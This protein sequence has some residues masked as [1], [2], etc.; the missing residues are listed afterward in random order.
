MSSRA[1]QVMYIISALVFA[2]M[3]ASGI[4]GLPGFGKYPGP[5]GDVI[6]GAVRA[7]RHIANAVTAIN[8]DYRGLDTLGEEFILF[9]A[10]TGVTLLLRDQPPEEEELTEEGG[11]PGRQR[12]GPSEALQWTGRAVMGA[13]LIFGLYII[14]HPQPSPGGGFQGGAIIGSASILVCLATNHRTYG[15]V[16]SQTVAEA[17][18]AGG[19]AGYILAGLAALFLGGNFLQNFLPFGDE[20]SL[21]AGGSIWIINA[22]VGLEVGSGFTVLF[23]EFYKQMHRSPE[24]EAPS[25]D[26]AEPAPPPAK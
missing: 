11:V 26:P 22:C 15:K 20:Q 19:G 14:S 5:Y 3:L 9:A 7:E 12:Y 6:N 1:R 10:V 25:D 4:A 8:F 21:F 2:A 24:G 18:E 17:V 23:L 13:I 16:V